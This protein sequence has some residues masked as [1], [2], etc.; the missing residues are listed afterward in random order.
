MSVQM[1]MSPSPDHDNTSGSAVPD[2]DAVG[3]GGRAI[4][5]A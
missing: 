4:L 3:N 2:F 1:A 5:G